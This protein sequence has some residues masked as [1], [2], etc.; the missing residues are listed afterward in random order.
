MTSNYKEDIETRHTLW[1][2]WDLDMEVD[3][4]LITRSSRL[5]LD[6]C[7]LVLSSAVVLNFAWQTCLKWLHFT[8]TW[9][10]TCSDL[11]L[12]LDLLETWLDILADRFETWTGLKWLENWLGLTLKD[13][14]TTLLSQSSQLPQN[15]N[16]LVFKKNLSQWLDA[17]QIFSTSCLNSSSSLWS[18][19]DNF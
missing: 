10:R 5:D 12:D 7:D 4:D 15:L 18:S 17:S 19:S 9:L 8:I 13:L 6:L 11:K 1:Q 16:P 2:V 14:K 3:M